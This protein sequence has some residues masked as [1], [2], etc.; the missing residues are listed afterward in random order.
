M[1]SRNGLS[2]DEAN[3]SL[4]RRFWSKVNKNGPVMPEMDTP[5]WVWTGSRNT[6]GYGSIGTGSRRD[7][8]RRTEYAHRVA[9]VVQFGTI[10]EGK[11]VLHRCDHPPC[12]RH[13]FLGD[14]VA[15]MDDMATKGRRR[16]VTGEAHPSARLTA[17]EVQAI[18]ARYARGG[19]SQKSLAQACGVGPAQ[20]GR[21]VR[22]ERWRPMGIA[23]RRARCR[24]T[25]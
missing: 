23:E 12:V 14:H 25:L 18:R 7:G 20:V 24:S 2:P 19:V 13:L 21:I 22:G 11:Q 9:W 17:V 10:P 5:C 3:R 16:S 4:V 1:A 8:T 15:N 6:D